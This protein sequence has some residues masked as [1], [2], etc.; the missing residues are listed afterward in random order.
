MV[1]EVEDLIMELSSHHREM[2]QLILMT[3]PT[4]SIQKSM[5]IIQHFQLTAIKCEP[6]IDYVIDEFVIDGKFIPEFYDSQMI[7]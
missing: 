4:H 2:N 7:K 3:Y 1:K 5:I 6:T